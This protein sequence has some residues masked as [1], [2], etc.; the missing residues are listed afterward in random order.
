MAFLLSCLEKGGFFSDK[1]SAPTKEDVLFLLEKCLLLT[2]LSKDSVQS[3]IYSQG[4]VDKS[5]LWDI[6]YIPVKEFALAV[7]PD[8]SGAR[9]LQKTK[10]AS[11]IVTEEKSD[12]LLG[13]HKGTLFLQSLRNLKSGVGLNLQNIV[14]VGT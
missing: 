8:F 6:P 3:V 4:S 13:Y 12:V 11:G 10:K 9:Y 7:Y 14:G 5:S 1:D 2:G